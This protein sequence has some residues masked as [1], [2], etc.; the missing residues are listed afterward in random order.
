MILKVLG[1][2]FL[3][4]VLGRGLVDPFV[5]EK[6]YEVEEYHLGFSVEKN[7]S[8]REIQLILKEAGFYAGQV[9]G[10]LGEET[11]KAVRAFQKKGRLR[12]TGKIDELTL[13]SL[14]KWKE[15]QAQASNDSE[16]Q[17]GLPDD[18]AAAQKPAFV[19]AENESDKIRQVQTALKKAGYYKGKV[20]GQKGRKT[21][22]ALKA[23]QVSAGL[24]SDGI[25]GQKTLDRLK[26]LMAGEG[27]GIDR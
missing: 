18:Q 6:K 25:A 20:D 22:K 24:V 13:G 9:D 4:I 26:I 27:N 5:K 16:V 8:V 14:R 1:I 2:V 3:V 11:R 23:F 7:S 15:I 10:F 17:V 12:P 21:R 19:W